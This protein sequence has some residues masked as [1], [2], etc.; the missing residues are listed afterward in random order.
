MTV[1]AG[2]AAQLRA[3]AAALEAGDETP[4]QAGAA[5]ADE[6]VKAIA[7]RAKGSIVAANLVGRIFST[8]LTDTTE[9]G[10]IVNQAGGEAEMWL[11]GDID[12]WGGYW[13]VSADEFRAE[14]EQLT[15][16]HLTLHVNSYGGEVFE[17]LAIR[18]A[19][20]RYPGSVTVT[21][22]A[23]AASIASV[24]ALAGTRVEMC[25]PSM[26]MIHD[27]SGFC[28]GN[29]T[30]MA[31]MADLLDKVSNQLAGVYAAKAGGT[32]EA[33]RDLMRSETWYG[34]GEAVEAGLADAV[35]EATPSD[36]AAET[37]EPAA[38]EAEPDPYAAADLHSVA[39]HGDDTPAEAELPAG[40][41]PPDPQPEPD[42]AP[43]APVVDDPPAGTDP[44]PTAPAEDPAA[45]QPQDDWADVIAHFT[46]NP[47]DTLT[48]AL[49]T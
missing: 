11:Y 25:D 49:L 33:W 36:P 31:Q 32:V 28:Y 19:L 29:A 2:N 7:A 37:P 13:G 12:S 10:V 20:M 17:G 3:M 18:T 47:W 34:A 23:I 8:V 39:A 16:P 38:P 43:A 42:P 35:S 44:E 48:E 30:E 26:L 4:L 1:V 5:E 14:L 46:D 6:R 21:V 24:I 45:D 15:A 22:D 40:T 27:A 41:E 9:P